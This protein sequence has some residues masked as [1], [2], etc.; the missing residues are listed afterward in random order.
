MRG[1]SVPIPGAYSNEIAI[2]RYMR[3]SYQEYL[4]TPEHVI[5]EILM[6]MDREAHWSAEK[7]KRDASQA[8]Q[9]ARRKV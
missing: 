7:Q 1:E 9:R 8:E 3:W 6:R 2:M 5:S 4:A